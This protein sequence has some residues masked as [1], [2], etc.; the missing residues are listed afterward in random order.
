MPRHDF[1]ADAGSTGGA[2][3][4]VERLP[5]VRVEHVGCSEAAVRTVRAGGLT[6]PTVLPERNVITVRHVHFL[7]KWHIASIAKKRQDRGLR[8]VVPV[9]GLI[10]VSS[11]EC[12]RKAPST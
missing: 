6:V 11:N 2:A 5:A 10:F 9:A 7:T 1:F 8:N 4:S 12:S 3:R